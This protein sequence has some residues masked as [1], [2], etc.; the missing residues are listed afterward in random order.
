[1]DGKS[2]LPPIQLR[3]RSVTWVQ[4]GIPLRNQLQTTIALQRI[5]SL[6]VNFDQFG[7]SFLAAT[8]PTAFG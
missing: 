6:S 4:F 7:D 2:S 3:A 8:A 1:M 5:H